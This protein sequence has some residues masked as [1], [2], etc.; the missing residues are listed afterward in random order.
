[1]ATFLDPIFLPFS[2]ALGLLF[3][4]MALELIIA[5]LGGTLFG[6]GADL[7]L[8]TDFD[9]G[10]DA[11]L[12]GVD[13]L[14]L[15]D[16][17]LD[18][19]LGDLGEA[20]DVLPGAMDGPGDWLGISRAPVMVWFA[21]LLLGF[22]LTGLI[23]Q[24]LLQNLAGAAFPTSLAVLISG[25][26]GVGFAKRFARVF[27]RFIPKTE[28]AAL[29]ERSLGRRKGIVSQ[30]TAARGKP[31]EVR[32]IDGHGNTHYLRAEPLRDEAEIPQGTEVLVMRQ[33]RIGGYRLIA[34]SDL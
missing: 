15:G 31:A 9:V 29:S 24:T 13:G 25:V 22:G 1:M 28:S 32:I 18:F 20:P 12:D 16:A 19:E 7:D 17:D 21:A 14:D 3:G 33:A 2:F 10:L 26:F 23:L 6:M 27:A 5:L 8:D 30:G 11:G 34:V 4:L